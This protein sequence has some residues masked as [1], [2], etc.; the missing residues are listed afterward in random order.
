MDWREFLSSQSW[1]EGRVIC[2][3]PSS[4]RHRVVVVCYSQGRQT[5]AFANGIYNFGAHVEMLD[6][7][8]QWSP[9]GSNFVPVLPDGRLIMVVEQRPAQGRFG[10]QPTKLV[11][12]LGDV[13]LRSFGPY[14][15]LEFPGGSY[16][17]GEGF[18]AG[19]LRELVEETGVCEQ[20]AT[21]FFS[22]PIDI[23][24][25]DAAKQS[26]LG[27]LFLGKMK[28]ETFT[29]SD[30]GLTVLAL[31]EEDVWENISLG[32]IT[33]GQAALMPWWFY[34]DVKS[35]LG[36]PGVYARMQNAG[37]FRREEVVIKK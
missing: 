22:R 26:N 33:S 9:S 2:L 7:R 29:P 4:Y 31:S 3:P 24:G 1:E 28:H 27:V 36:N 30:G 12:I 34:R 25:C 11:T 17:E 35:A 20:T 14:S 15:S 6:G 37:Y 19:I 10:N 23:F 5:T 16:E 21:L 13:D 18:K 32:N 8:G